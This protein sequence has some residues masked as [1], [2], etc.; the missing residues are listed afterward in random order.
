MRLDA[1]PVPVSLGGG[2]PASR[3][4]GAEAAAERAARMLAAGDRDGAVDALLEF[5]RD[6]AI[7]E[8]EV[9]R[10]L[11]VSTRT[12]QWWRQIGDGP[13]WFKLSRA[14]RGRVRY[15]R[16]AVLSY[17]DGLACRCTGDVLGGAGRRRSA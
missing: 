1:R 12:L 2:R 11:G 9:A 7:G 8:A 6:D 15:A 5:L 3:R 17:R 16:S 13:P 10:L 14:P 4:A